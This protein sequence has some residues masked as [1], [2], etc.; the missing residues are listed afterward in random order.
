MQFT[1]MQPK[2]GAQKGTSSLSSQVRDWSYTSASSSV[3]EKRMVKS[4]ILKLH[5]VRVS[6]G[7]KRR[8]AHTMMKRATLF[9]RLLAERPYGVSISSFPEF[10]EVYGR[11]DS[12]NQNQHPSLHA[13]ILLHSYMFNFQDSVTWDEAS[14]AWG[15]SMYS[16]FCCLANSYS[17]IPNCLFLFYSWHKCKFWY[18]KT[19]PF[20]GEELRSRKQFT[21]SW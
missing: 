6:D 3:P 5:W 16:W 17:K 20:V 1:L 7:W 13:N 15:V 19:W 11:Q 21:G 4:K 18:Q 14:V 2:S 12:D 9:F 8:W 10:V